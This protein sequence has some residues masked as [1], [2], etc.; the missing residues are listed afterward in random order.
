M[1]ILVLF[2]S[3]SLSLSLFAANAWN[4]RMQYYDNPFGVRATLAQNMSLCMTGTYVHTNGTTIGNVN[5]Y[6]CSNLADNYY[7]L[8]PT[9]WRCVNAGTLYPTVQVQCQANSSPCNSPDVWDQSQFT[10]GRCILPEVWNPLVERCELNPTE[11]FCDVELPQGD[12]WLPNGTL[13]N[14]TP[15]CECPDGQSVNLNNFTCESPPPPDCSSMPDQPVGS[16]WDSSTNSCQC[17]PDSAVAQIYNTTTGTTYGQCSPTPCPAGTGSV[18]FGDQEACLGLP[19]PETKTDDSTTISTDLSGLPIDPSDPNSP[20]YPSGTT[21][22]TTT[23]HTTNTSNGGSTTTTTTTTTNADGTSQTKTDT[24]SDEPERVAK[25]GAGCENPPVC[26][27]DA[28]DCQILHQTWLSRCD[29][30]R[31]EL[32]GANDC[33]AAFV[34][35]SD[36]ALCALLLNQKEA[37]CSANE[38]QEVTPEAIALENADWA[39]SSGLASLDYLSGQS[40]A[41]GYS[42]VSIIPASE[43]DLP[44]ES[45]LP[46]C[47]SDMPLFIGS[48]GTVNIPLSQYCTLFQYIYYL[49]T[50]TA[51]ITAARFNYTAIQSI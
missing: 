27:G 21:Q 40:T 46:A 50:I 2:V 45:S 7:H 16:A 15:R 25:G 8:N 10:C 26:G 32:S 39:A 5:N 11:N 13:D 1:R 23:T 6:K 33:N 48:F 36:P 31:G 3:L 43:I 38:N 35:N 12:F 37:A 49:V 24:V 17:S 18:T 41:N 47:I 29:N 34:C 20:T 9:P 22:T 28:I 42:M 19:D 14:P 51:L 4:I 30:D 44:S